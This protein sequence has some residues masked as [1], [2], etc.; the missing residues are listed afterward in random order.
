MTDKLGKTMFVGDVIA[1]AAANHHRGVMRVGVIVKHHPAKEYTS[2]RITTKFF[3]K[4]ADNEWQVST[5]VPETSQC[6]GLDVT[7]LDEDLQKEI[8]KVQASI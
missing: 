5:G 4:G 1:Y 7:E 8:E 2:E 6:I 3:T